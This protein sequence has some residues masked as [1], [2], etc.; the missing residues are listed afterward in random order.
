MSEN[1]T[2]KQLT[3]FAEDSLANLTVQPGSAE[4]Q[5]MTATS[6]QN[7]SDL[8]PSSTPLGSLVKMFLESSR[9]CSTRCY[10]TWKVRVMKFSR[11]LFRLVPSMP[12]IDGNGSFLWPTPT[13]QEEI[14]SQRLGGA[15]EIYIDR[16]GKPRRR[17]SPGRSA[18]MGLGKMAAMGMWPTPTVGDS[19]GRRTSK[20]AKELYSAGPTLLEKV[21]GDRPGG[22]LNPQW[23]EWLMGFPIGWT[24]LEPSE[25]P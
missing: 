2:S 14:S 6:G 25:T 13:A 4:A 11:L 10:L 12:R 24:D 7:I 20:R 16:T 5:Q 23:V 8:L 3:L 17:T 9:P 1:T 22:K 19:K 21:W 18:S 15:L